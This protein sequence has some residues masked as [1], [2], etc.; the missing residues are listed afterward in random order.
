ME[1]LDDL[2]VEFAQRTK[3]STK[4]AK[5]SVDVLWAIISEQPIPIQYRLINQALIYQE[6]INLNATSRGPE[7][8]TKKKVR[9]S[10]S[11]DFGGSTQV[12]GTNAKT[13]WYWYFSPTS[14]FR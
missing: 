1:N 8:R 14:W 5:E 13:Q 10:E 2:Y 11:S 6:T 7:P 3:C 4:K 9:K 12:S